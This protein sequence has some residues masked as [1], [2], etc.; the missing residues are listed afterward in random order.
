VDERSGNPTVI[1][2][3]WATESGISVWNLSRM[4]TRLGFSEWWRVVGYPFSFLPLW[5]SS[6]GLAGVLGFYT[7]HLYKELYPR[8]PGFNTAT[9]GYVEVFLVGLMVKNMCFLLRGH[10]FKSRGG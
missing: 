9:P 1:L 7:F 10:R 5:L 2:V 4:I 3:V 6:V 8:F